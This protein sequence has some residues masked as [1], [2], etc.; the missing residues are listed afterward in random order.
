VT[1]T[2][3][4]ARPAPYTVTA[5]ASPLFRLEAPPKAR[6]AFAPAEPSK[7][8]ERSYTYDYSFY[9]DWLRQREN[10]LAECRLS[11]KETLQLT[12]KH[13]RMNDGQHP[14]TWPLHQLRELELTFRRLMFPLLTGGIVAPISLVALLNSLLTP[15]IGIGLA[16]VGLSLLYYGWV[17]T[18]QVRIHFKSP[19]S[20][21]YF[22]DTKTDRIERFVTKANLR[23]EA[24]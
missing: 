17:G 14:K 2:T 16:L 1:P 10:V 19:T 11:E 24:G 15:L 4:T 18:Y 8:W 7:N 3:T 6:R 13:L 21:A 20:V 12:N 22:A 9:F 23:L 5:T